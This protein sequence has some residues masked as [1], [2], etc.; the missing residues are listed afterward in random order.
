M[1]PAA[2]EDDSKQNATTQPSSNITMSPGSE[3]Y[4]LRM[5]CL[6]RRSQLYRILGLYSLAAADSQQALALQIKLERH[7]QEQQPIVAAS[8]NAVAAASTES[9]VVLDPSMLGTAKTVHSGAAEAASVKTKQVRSNFRIR[10][11]LSCM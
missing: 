2:Q 3:P 8:E 10:F 5:K 11:D 7:L 1:P 4:Q 6:L 9:T